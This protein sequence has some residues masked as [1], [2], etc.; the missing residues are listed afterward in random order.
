MWDRIMSLIAEK[1][2]TIRAE[3]VV[4]PYVFLALL[5]VCA[6]FF[7]YSIYRLVRALA[8]KKSDLVVRWSSVFLLATA[9]PYLY[10]LLFGRHMPWWVYPVLAVLLGQGVFSLVRKLRKGR[11]NAGE[12]H[13]DESMRE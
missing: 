6:P 1:A 13:A 12:N 11:G 4:N 10:V 5:V 7:Y 9:T 2:E 8:A 3:Y